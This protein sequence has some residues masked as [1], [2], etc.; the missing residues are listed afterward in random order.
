M[1]R[2]ELLQYVAPALLGA[3]VGLR[4]FS[5]LS[6]PQFNTVVSAFLLLSGLLL[7]IKAL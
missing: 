5:R 3:Y 7:S 4:I 6:T 2:L 1:M